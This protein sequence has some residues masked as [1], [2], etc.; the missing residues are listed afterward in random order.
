[1]RAIRAGPGPV[2]ATAARTRAGWSVILVSLGTAAPIGR[3]PDVLH[4]SAHQLRELDPALLERGDLVLDLA[5]ALGERL[6]PLVV[7]LVVLGH[8]PVQVVHLGAQPVEAALDR[9][10]LLLGRAALGAGGPRRARRRVGGRG[11]RAGLLLA[12]QAQV[13]LDPA[14]EVPQPPV[15]DRVLLV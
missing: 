2:G 7:A 1:R 15:E 8:A 9:G 4:R 12:A 13:L 3:G 14:G 11:G 6:Q 10:D 5:Q